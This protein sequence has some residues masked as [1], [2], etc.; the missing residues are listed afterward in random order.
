M[1]ETAT[2]RTEGLRDF[3]TVTES[4][5]IMAS[6]EQLERLYTRYIFASGYCNGGETLEVAV[7]RRDRAGSARKAF[8]KSRRGGHRF[9]K[10]GG[11][12]EDLRVQE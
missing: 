5:G 9:G 8:K 4:P 10:S 11:S 1:N 7:R 2:I 3:T 6:R 12:K